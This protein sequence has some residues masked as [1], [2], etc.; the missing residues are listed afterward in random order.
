M[1]TILKKIKVFKVVL[2]IDKYANNIY[3]NDLYFHEYRIVIK[4]NELDIKTEVFP[5]K[6]HVKN[7]SKR[8]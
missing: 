6:L 2:M 4:H 5:T 7:I 8:Y 3:S 1:D